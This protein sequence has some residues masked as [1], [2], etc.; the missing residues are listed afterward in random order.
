[1][2]REL[3]ALVAERVMG[4]V[5]SA[6]KECGCCGGRGS[7][8]Q[9]GHGREGRRTRPVLK[10]CPNCHGD[11]RVGVV[12]PCGYSTSIASAWGVVERCSLSILNAHP[13]YV[14]GNRSDERDGRIVVELASEKTMPLAACIAALRAVGV[15]E[16]TI[17]KARAAP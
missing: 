6:G 14:V 8:P 12:K 4:I 9:S 3:D 10:P 15:D 2:S 7:Y 16:S 1:M 5:L 13:F 17:E 11:K